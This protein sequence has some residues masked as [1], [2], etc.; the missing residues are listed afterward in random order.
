[1]HALSD[2][3]LTLFV[4]STPGEPFPGNGRV[5]KKTDSENAPSVCLIRPGQ[6]AS[7]SDKQVWYFRTAP[8]QKTLELKVAQRDGEGAVH[9]RTRD[10]SM[11]IAHIGAD[12]RRVGGDGTIQVA[13]EPSAFYYMAVSGGPEVTP[14]EYPLILAHTA[15]LWFEPDIKRAD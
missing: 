1:L 4:E 9:I 15:E 14:A 8:D 13:V 6:S 2:A 11:I 3:K 12:G 5:V 10:G 7:L